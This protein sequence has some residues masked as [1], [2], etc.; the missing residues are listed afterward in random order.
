MSH[1]CNGVEP[2]AT[3]K[4]SV[5]TR[6]HGRR[7]SLCRRQA[8]PWNQPTDARFEAVR[9]RHAPFQSGRTL[10]DLRISHARSNINL[11]CHNRPVSSRG[12][13]DLLD[14]GDEPAPRMPLRF[15]LRAQP[16]LVGGTAYL[17][18]RRIPAQL[19]DG[20]PG[21]RRRF[22]CMPRRRPPRA[23]GGARSISVRAR[24][25]RSSGR[26]SGPRARPLFGA[27]AEIL[28]SGGAATDESHD[29]SGFL[30]GDR[31]PEAAPYRFAC[32]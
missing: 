11:S 29:L 4:R 2:D 16:E 28:D 27:D 9:R 8:G 24:Y 18:P 6:R 12:K 32:D 15:P 5:F 17:R 3:G 25:V 31:R 7:G 26:G 19:E 20:G 13:P 21:L 1:D 30:R 22:R 14:Q 23:Y 10:H